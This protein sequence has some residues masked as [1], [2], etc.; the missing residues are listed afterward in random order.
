MRDRLSHRSFAL[1]TV[2]HA[3][4]QLVVTGRLYPALAAV[5]PADWHAE[6]DAHSRRVVP[7]VGVLYG[8][9]LVTGLGALKGRRDRSLVVALVV[10]GVAVLTT[11]LVA[12]PLH[13]R[14]GSGR[15]GR[16]LH[17]LLAADRLRTLAAVVG[18]IG[19]VRAA[20]S[21]RP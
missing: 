21:A 16:D 3:A 9:V 6:H 19:A 4:F 17:R 5:P 11:A 8:A 18:A 7:W 1:A 2:A 10:E 15:S 13:R 12:A 20:V 14:L